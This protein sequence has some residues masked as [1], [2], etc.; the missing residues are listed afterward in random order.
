MAGEW[1]HTTLGEFVSLQRGHDL[2]EPERKPGAVPVMGSAGQNGF[3]DTA[4]VKGPGIVI[5]R[6][7]A[8]FGQV[9]YCPIDYWPHNTTLYVTDFH[10]NDPQFAY[11]FLKSINFARYNSGSA[12]P[13]LNRNFIYPI[14]VDVPQFDE[15]RAIAHILGTLDDKIEL[16]RRMNETLEAIT[17]A[18]FKSWFV[19]FDPVRAKASGEPPESICRRLGLTPDLLALFPERLVVSELGEI[20]EGWDVKPLDMI[21]DYLNGLA[22][23]KFPPESET[24]W[25]PV[26]KIAQLKKGDTSGADRASHKLKSDYVVNDGDVLFS[27][28]GSLA[29]DIWCGGCGALNQHLFKVSSANYPKWF[30]YQWTKHH[31]ANFQAIAAGKAVTMGHIQR[32]HLT[33]A[34]CVVPRKP[35]MEML[36]HIMEPLLGKQIENRK[37]SRTLSMVRDELLPKLLSGELNLIS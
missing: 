37:E 28:S 13:S 35:L 22:L 26:I 2:T 25:L 23:Q 12:Q 6:S 24:E 9:H 10:G 17:R 7:G 29:V 33:Q 30:Y 19:D 14:E 34:L 1:H 16:N 36:E 27:W 4:L 32:K 20:P 31:L 21:A 18:I 5:G 15:Q 3:H 8:S 11:Y